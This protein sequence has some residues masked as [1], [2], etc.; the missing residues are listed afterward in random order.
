M[1]APLKMKPGTASST[2]LLMVPESPWTTTSMETPCQVMAAI[3][4]TR[5]II[6]IGMPSSSSTKARTAIAVIMA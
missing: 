2:S 4:R 1:T 5:K 3:A 6:H